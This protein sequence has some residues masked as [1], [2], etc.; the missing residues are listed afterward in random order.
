MSDP[1][2]SL[3]DMSAADLRKVFI[4]R[5]LPRSEKFRTFFGRSTDMNRI[6]AALR[7][8]DFGLMVELTDLESE[9]LGLDP[10]CSSV[11]SKRFRS[12][13]CL[14][15]DLELPTGPDVDKVEAEKIAAKVRQDFNRIPFFKERIYDLMWA[16]YDGRAVLENHWEKSMGP[17]PWRICELRWVHPRRVSFGPRRELRIINPFNLRGDFQRDGF[18]VDEFP[19]KFLWW[20]PRHFREYPEREGLAPRTLY[21]TFFKRFSWRN[22]MIFTELFGVPWRIVT[23]EADLAQ[24]S[25]VEE[26]RDMAENLG[27]EST[28]AFDPGV[29]VDI[30]QPNGEHSELFGMN[31]DQVNSEISKLVLGNTGTTDPDANRANSITQKSEQD[32]ILQAD[33]GGGGE[34]IDHFLVRPTVVM[35][36]GASSL[37]NAPKFV[38]KAAPQR[39]IEKEQTVADKA[40]Q[41]GVP[42]AVTQ[43]RE[44]TNLREPEP[45]EEIIVSAPGGTDP[46]TGAALPPT[47]QITKVAPELETATD[48][49][50]AAAK[51]GE[52]EDGGNDAAAAKA[53]ADALGVAAERAGGP[54]AAP[55]PE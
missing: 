51:V 5:K 16:N 42:V 39:D 45:G 4:K 35:N 11:L 53:V 24:G 46:F 25:S 22:R 32:I 28:A 38:I 43:Y 29:K 6:E 26:A 50:D 31:N 40:I 44:I 37:V 41:I 8:A 13:Q 12:V 1:A 48:P 52:L 23:Q 54:D 27:Q 14:D 55:F 17:L 30:V 7:Q 3:V 34:R 9:S 15:W 18:A 19:G 2:L 21:W 47:T 49:D 10:H 33:A 36:F 20:Q